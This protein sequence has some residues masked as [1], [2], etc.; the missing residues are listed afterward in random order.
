MREYDSVVDKHRS[1]SLCF[2]ATSPASYGHMKLSLLILLVSLPAFGQSET[3]KALAFCFKDGMAMRTNSI[4][5]DV[6]TSQLGGVLRQRTVDLRCPK[7]KARETITQ[8]IWV[9]DLQLSDE[10]TRC[11]NG[12]VKPK[13]FQ[14]FQDPK[15]MPKLPLPRKL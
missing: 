5:R 7:C 1:G 4:V 12:I 10:L 9:E 15:R 14:G 3:N 6:G 8:T 11:T 13:P 2:P